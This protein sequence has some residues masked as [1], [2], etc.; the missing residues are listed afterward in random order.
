MC[1]VL[2]LPA[3]NESKKGENKTGA[4][5]SLYTVHQVMTDE[6]HNEIKWPYLEPASS[7]INSLSFSNCLILS[8]AFLNCFS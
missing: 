3:D 1:L 8:W 6:E 4:H 5:I 7:L 2:N